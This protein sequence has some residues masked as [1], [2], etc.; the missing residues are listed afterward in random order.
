M[1]LWDKKIAFYRNWTWKK[2]KENFKRV[3][4]GRIRT[5]NLQISSLEPISVRLRRHQLLEATTALIF[6]V[7]TKAF[8]RHTAKT[9]EN[10]N[11]KLWQFDIPIGALINDILQS[12]GYGW[13]HK[14]AFLPILCSKIKTLSWSPSYVCDSIGQC[15]PKTDHLEHL[16]DI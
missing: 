4:P 9:G 8:T 13:L 14:I 5:L 15:L 3:P 12:D 7:L 11:F 1:V 6:I 16:V 2:D 10:G